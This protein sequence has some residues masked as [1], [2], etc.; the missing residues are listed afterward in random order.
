[1]VLQVA[2]EA[3][4]YA[5][6]PNRQDLTPGFIHLNPRQGEIVQVGYL[7]ALMCQIE[8]ARLRRTLRC[9]GGDA[10]VVDLE[11]SWLLGAA[12]PHAGGPASRLLFAFF[13]YI[14][15]LIGGDPLLPPALGLDEQLYRLLALSLLGAAEPARRRRRRSAAANGQWGPELDAL[16]DYIRAE[17]HQNL[18]LTDL[19]LQSHYSARHLQTLFRQK[20]DCTPMQFVRRQRLELALQKLQSAQPADTVTSIARACGYR[21]I[22]N[23]STDFQRCFGVAPSRVLRASQRQR[24]DP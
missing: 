15:D 11:D 5:T 10:V 22:S 14:D 16:V 1:M 3:C 2:G 6:G 17:V 4:T 20:F 23:F 18:T 19:E 7:S 12:S 9:I 8:H 21:H 24:T 13:A